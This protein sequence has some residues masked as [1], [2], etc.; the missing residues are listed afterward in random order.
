MRRFYACRGVTRMEDKK[1]T[2]PIVAFSDYSVNANRTSGLRL[3]PAV[4]IACNEPR[5]DQAIPLALNLAHNDVIGILA[6]SLNLPWC[7][8]VSAVFFSLAMT[9]AKGRARDDLAWLITTGV[10]AYL[11]H[12]LQ[13]TPGTPAIQITP[14]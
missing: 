7:V 6:F 14:A 2:R 1:V 12:G 10:F 3:D 13:S 11:R 4:P 8:H 5:E 9:R